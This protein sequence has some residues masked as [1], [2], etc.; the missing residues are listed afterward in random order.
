MSRYVARRRVELGLADP[1]GVDPADASGRGGGR[2]RLRRVLLHDR[3]C[4]REV[5]DVRDATVP[6]GQGVSRRVRHPGPG[7]LPGGPCAGLRVLRRR[8]GPD[9]V[10]QPQTRRRPGAQGPRP[11]RV[12]TVHRA[13]QPLRVRLVLLP[14]RHRGRPREGRRG[15]R[16]RPLPAPPPR[17]GPEGRLAGGA[18]RA[19]RRR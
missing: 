3:R 12:R 10:R 11:D 5:L 1:R 4:G 2:G 17:P 19:D 9:P 14:P 7:S 18:Q 16:D 6:L 8:A 13:A 15:G